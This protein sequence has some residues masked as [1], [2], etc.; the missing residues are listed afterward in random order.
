MKDIKT[1]FLKCKFVKLLTKL[2]FTK[3]NLF[4]FE[5]G[6]IEIKIGNI[7]KEEINDTVNDKIIIK[8]KSI[9]GLISVITK[10]AKAIIVV[11][12]VYKQGQNMLDIVIFNFE[13]L[14]LSSN[15]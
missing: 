3:D 13:V 14:V 4:E 8:P 6:N 1:I 15:L 7:T 12:D 10:E 9:T 2:K 11:K 5:S